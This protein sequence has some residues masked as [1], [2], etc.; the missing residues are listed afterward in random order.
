MDRWGAVGEWPFVGKGLAPGD[1]SSSEYSWERG[2]GA[3]N[4]AKPADVNVPI[5]SRWEVSCGSA[6]KPEPGGGYDNGR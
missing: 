6:N 4:P 1:L 5:L 3:P 2:E